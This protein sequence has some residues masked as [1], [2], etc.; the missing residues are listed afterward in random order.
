[1]ARYL[2]PVH[3]LARREGVDLFLKG[4]HRR[5]E[6]LE[7]RLGKPPGQSRERRA[8]ISDYGIQ[9]REKQKLKRIYGLLERQFRVFFKRA[10]KQRGVTGENLV[11]LLERR[12][13][14][15]VFRSFF[16]A[17]R[18]EARQLVGHGHICVN[19]RRVDIPSFLVKPGDRIE[20]MRKESTMSQLKAR[21]EMYKDLAVP[22]W[23]SLNRDELEATVLRYPTKADAALPV[24]ESL[25]VELYSK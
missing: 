13:D 16:A 4:G 17:S 24:E 14:N 9:L 19:G 25:V 15:V 7:K 12:L 8:K 18:R 21:V 3:R 2:G 23:L 5:N 22:T 10:S 6:K 11:Q 20:P 1:M